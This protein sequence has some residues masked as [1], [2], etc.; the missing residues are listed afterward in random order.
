MVDERGAGQILL[1]DSR[2][3]QD[4][5]RVDRAHQA[6]EVVQYLPIF[7]KISQVVELGHVSGAEGVATD[8]CAVMAE[9]CVLFLD[10]PLMNQFSKDRL[11]PGRLRK[12]ARQARRDQFQDQLE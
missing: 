1:T 4:C 12:G 5:A 10:T 11:V 2:V 3:D 7:M 8:L 6:I 9:T